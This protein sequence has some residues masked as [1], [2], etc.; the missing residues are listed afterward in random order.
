LFAQSDAERDDMM[1][2]AEMCEALDGGPGRSPMPPYFMGFLCAD[3]G[4]EPL[5]E[6]E[7]NIHEPGPERTIVLRAQD[8]TAA[9]AEARAK[10]GKATA[11]AKP[12]AISSISRMVFAYTA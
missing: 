8:V 1:T 6:G 9:R 10:D 4:N 3:E 7:I 5:T 11:P 12:T 2:L